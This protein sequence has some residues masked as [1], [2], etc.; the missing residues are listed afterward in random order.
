MRI[1]ILVSREVALSM[2]C[3]IRAILFN[4]SYEPVPILRD[5]FI[6]PNFGAYHPEAVEPN[7]GHPEQPLVLQPF[8]F[9]GRERV[10]NP[11]NTG[12]ME[13]RA[14]YQG[15]DGRKEIDKTVTITIT[16]GP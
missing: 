2:E 3:H 10:Y 8:T 13:I 16:A 5:A 1:E 6:G 14:Y 7:Y 12:D 4:D 9:Y 11:L 15:S